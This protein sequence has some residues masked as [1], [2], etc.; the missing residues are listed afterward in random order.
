VTRDEVETFYRRYL[1]ACNAHDF[2]QL[3]AFVAADVQVNGSRQ[4][5]DGY[6]AGLRDVVRAFPDYRWDL[7]DLLIEGDRIAAHFIDTG[8]HRAEA[9]GVPATGRSVR[10]QEF[11]FYRLADGLIAEVWVT[12]GNLELLHQLE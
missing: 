10:T 11:A 2:D 7:R 3:G 9:F 4:G 1:T 12:A 6:V 8:T 5:L